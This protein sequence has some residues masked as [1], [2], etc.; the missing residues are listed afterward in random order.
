[1][2][3]SKTFERP[4]GGAARVVALISVGKIRTWLASKTRTYSDFYLKLFLM[5][6]FLSYGVMLLFADLP[7]VA[8]QRLYL[9]ARATRDGL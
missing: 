2:L 3:A 5:N 8:R 1:M 6:L 9:E 7:F 4:K